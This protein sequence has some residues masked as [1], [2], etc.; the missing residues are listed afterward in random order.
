MRAPLRTGRLAAMRDSSIF[1]RWSRT[2][3]M[4]VLAALAGL[5]LFGAFFSFSATQPLAGRFGQPDY[6]YAF[7]QLAY[8]SVAL[9]LMV[10]VSFLP[11]QLVRSGAIFAMFV[12]VLL[13]ILTFVAGSEAKGATRWLRLGGLSLQPSEFAKPAF[14]L[15]AAWLLFSADGRLRHRATFCAAALF[16]SLS[17]LLL[18]QPDFGQFFIVLSIFGLQFFV[19]GFSLWFVIILA[20][21]GVVGLVGAYFVFP[22]VAE[23]IN[24]FLDP[25]TGDTYQIERSMEGFAAG[26]I[27]GVGLA[28]G[29]VKQRLPDAHSDFVFAVIGE[30]LGFVLSLAVILAFAFVVVRVS[31]LLI[32]EQRRYVAI[33][34]MGL[35]AQFIMQVF[36]NIGSS[37]QLIPTKGMTLPFLS[38]GGSSL[39]AMGLGMGALLALL[40]RPAAAGAGMGGGMSM[41]AG[42]GAR[43][44]AGIAARRIALEAGRR[45]P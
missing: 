32:R 33:A 3:D 7:R 25:A 10:A 2:V 1:A 5:I 17:A 29:Q 4:P 28:Q 13:L 40:R 12:S 18:L 26:G 19:A 21:F 22:H 6:I 23:R 9:G 41:G 34:G 31:L 36:V 8:A 15:T 14:A 43:T 27:R 44:G 20:L 30:E 37:L 45:T 39:V 11:V 38:Y 24:I 16:A 35:I 42:V